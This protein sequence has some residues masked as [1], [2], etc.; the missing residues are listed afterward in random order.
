[1]AACI[2]DPCDA[3][4]KGVTDNPAPVASAPDGR[5]NSRG[6]GR[7][8][9][10]WLRDLLGADRAVVEAKDDQVCALVHQLNVHENIFNRCEQHEP[11]KNPLAR[12]IQFHPLSLAPL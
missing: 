12:P 4:P 5:V 11:V 2:A 6:R 7:S 8:L 10:D 1:L 3:A 9:R